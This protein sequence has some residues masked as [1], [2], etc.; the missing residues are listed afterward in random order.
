MSR[1]AENLVTWFCM[2]AGFILLIIL[3]GNSIEFQKKCEN[4]CGDAQ[5]ITPLVD[6]SEVCFCDEGHGKWRRELDVR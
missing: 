3:A 4:R 1:E 5:V 6:F 2:F